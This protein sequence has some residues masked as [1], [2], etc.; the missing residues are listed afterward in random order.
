MNELFESLDIN[1][2]MKANLAEAFDKAVLAKSVEMMDEHVSVKVE[3]AKTLM[4]AEYAE[5]VEG[6]EDTLDGYMTSVVEEFVAEQKSSYEAE[7]LDEKAKK[8]LEMFDSMLTVAGVAMTDINEARSDRDIAE[9]ADSLENQ[10]ERLDKRLSEKEADLHEARKEADK[11]LK[12]GFIA[13]SKKGLTMVE[14][15]KFEKLA[16]MV[17]FERSEKYAD[18]LDTIKESILDSRE[19]K[20][21]ESL[22]NAETGELPTKAFKPS[23]VDAKSAMDFSKYV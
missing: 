17:T 13:E 14:S 12:A 8:L 22:V 10:I 4:E 2:D 20:F 11:Y 7:I 9:D 21:N 16:E 6:L 5:K 23:E 18:A 15:D 1:D 19:E 3:E